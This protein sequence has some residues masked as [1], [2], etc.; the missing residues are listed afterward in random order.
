MPSAHNINSSNTIDITATKHAI[1]RDDGACTNPP[2]VEYQRG[3]VFLSDC[4]T[5]WEH[6]AACG[7]RLGRDDRYRLSTPCTDDLCRNEGGDNFV[8]LG[9]CIRAQTE[10]T[11]V[12]AKPLG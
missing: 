12:C 9:E 1:F 7:V 3:E 5:R 10:K 11:C 2:I 6:D 8:A 4:D